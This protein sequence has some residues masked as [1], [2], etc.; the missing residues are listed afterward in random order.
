V[1]VKDASRF[2]DK[3]AYFGFDSTEP[4]SEAT[5]PSKNA[6]WTCHD[7]NAAVEHTFVQFYPSL[8]AIAKEKKTIKGGV[9][10]P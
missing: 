8:L 4:S 6:C 3:W 2:P 7:Q 5:S 10:L 9:K 1:E